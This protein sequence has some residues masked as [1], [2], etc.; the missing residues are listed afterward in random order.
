MYVDGCCNKSIGACCSVVDNNGN[1][2]ISEHIDFL[3][4]FRFLDWFIMKRHN[5]RLVYQVNFTDVVSQQ[6]NGA[7]LLAMLIGLMLG[8]KFEDYIIYSDSQLI[9]DYWSLK[10]SDKIKDPKKSKIQLAVIK[11]RKEY[12]RRGGKIVKISGNDNLADLGF[13]VKK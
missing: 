2:L 6:N 1:D 4:K 10:K 5:G 3:K 11:L 13:H 8:L 7:E 12:E 9:V